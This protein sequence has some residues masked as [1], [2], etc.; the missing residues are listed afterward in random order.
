MLDMALMKAHQLRPRTFRSCTCCSGPWACHA[1]GGT[2]WNPCPGWVG[3]SEGS[4][5]EKWIIYIMLYNH[6]SWFANHVGHSWV[7][8]CMCHN[9]SPPKSVP[10]SFLI[11]WNVFGGYTTR[12]F[13]TLDL[14]WWSEI[15]PIPHWDDPKRCPM[16]S[17]PP[18][19]T[20]TIHIYFAMYSP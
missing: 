9:C 13:A 14:F 2:W 19:Y 15:S 18:A 16:L 12:N 11:S 7:W 6:H 17:W 8:W 1:L 4:G 10:G 5:G 20:P 3:A